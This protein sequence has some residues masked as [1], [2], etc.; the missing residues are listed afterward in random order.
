MAERR[1]QHVDPATV[2]ELDAGV[3]DRSRAQEVAAHVAGC[4]ACSRIRGDLAE[5]SELLAT[6]PAPALPPEVA[7]RVDAALERA[8]RERGATASDDT[9]TVVH[10]PPRRRQWLAP[11][12]A[13][14]SVVAAVAVVGQV[15]QTPGGEGDAGMA[16]SSAGDTALSPEAAEGAEPPSP[17][18]LS[19][20]SFRRDV[21]RAL[22]DAALGDRADAVESLHARL[23]EQGCA[24]KR[25]ADGAQARP[26]LLDGKPALLFLSGPSSDRLAVAVTCETGDPEVAAK[27]R[28]DLR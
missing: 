6:A 4:P 10:L 5:L 9:G 17:L 20:S 19:T 24:P 3:L 16:G 22:T 21:T 8:V 15:V 28:L 2:A 27:A 26:V 25:F 18:L 1:E 11:L 13:A 12:A 23:R 7:A 14:A